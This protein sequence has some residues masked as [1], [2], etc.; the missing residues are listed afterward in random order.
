MQH[1]CPHCGASLKLRLLR[2]KALPGERR[3]LPSRAT[4]VCPA[5]GGRLAPNTHWSETA[6]S[7]MVGVP[8]LCF[9][10]ARPDL[11]LHA[12]AG[13]LAA[14]VALWVIA[15]A[16]FHWRYWR[17]WPRYKRYPDDPRPPTA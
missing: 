9:M 6:A 11:S 17:H 7:V 10:S 5:C 3:L 2:A 13:W 12:A 4:P 14:I 16:V 8:L 15:F 1:D